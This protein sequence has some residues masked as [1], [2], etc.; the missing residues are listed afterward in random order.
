M[1]FAD[2]LPFGIGLALLAMG[3]A[4]VV[5]IV[6]RNDMSQP[7][8]DPKKLFRELCRAHGL[9]FASRRLLYRLATAHQLAQPAE[10]FLTPAMFQAD[11]LP[12]Q[13]RAQAGQLQR[14]RQR[15]F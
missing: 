7:C 6:K 13:L 3:V 14:L 11:Q 5:A 10:V 8:D 1:D 15:L 12:P 2:L 4:I 9:D